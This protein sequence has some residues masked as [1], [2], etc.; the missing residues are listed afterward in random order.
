M[1]SVYVSDLLDDGLH[2]H[3]RAW[4]VTG[5]HSGLEVDD[6]SVRHPQCRPHLP[7]Q[8]ET[9]SSPVRPLPLAFSVQTDVPLAISVP[10][11]VYPRVGSL[12]CVCGKCPGCHGDAAED[13]PDEPSLPSCGTPD[14]A[15]GGEFLMCCFQWKVGGGSA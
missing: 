12:Q 15:G 4:D 14:G 7:L 2:P 3:H 6:P 11:S 8:G 1:L 13:R 10:R 9:S 5:S